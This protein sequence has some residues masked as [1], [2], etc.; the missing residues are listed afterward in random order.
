MSDQILDE[1]TCFD[2]IYREIEIGLDPKF[3]G[4]EERAIHRILDHM[5]YKYNYELK[6][7]LMDFRHMKFVSELGRI[8]DDQ[9]LIYWKI[10]AT[11]NTFNVSVGQLLRAKINRMGAEYCG[12]LMGTCIDATVMFAE[13]I[14]KEELMPYIRIGQE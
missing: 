10:G 3:I 8:I 9:P 6:G 1:T 5:K 4:N 11:F 14:D 2:T 13:D 12:A 7:V